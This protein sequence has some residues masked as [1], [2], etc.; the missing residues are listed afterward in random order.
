MRPAQDIRP[1]QDAR[2]WLVQHV[3]FLPSPQHSSSTLKPT[4]AWPVP[5]PSPPDQPAPPS[6][7]PHV[8]DASALEPLPQARVQRLG[9][10]M[11]R[12]LLGC[13]LSSSKAYMCTPVLQ[14]SSRLQGLTLLPCGPSRSG[15]LRLAGLVGYAS[16]YPK[17]S[18]HSPHPGREQG[19][20]NA[21]VGPEARVE[22]ACIPHHHA[23][24]LSCRAAG[25]L[26]Q[27]RLG[28]QDLHGLLHKGGCSA[29]RGG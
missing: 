10:H 25:G 7:R 20:E 5:V 23:Q 1:A 27:A 12:S 22:H 18:Q 19:P 29:W 8:G 28:N 2:S 17:A 15:R 24:N 21:C 3:P 4:Q 26:C 16:H 13:T 6:R 11:W 14:L 9:P